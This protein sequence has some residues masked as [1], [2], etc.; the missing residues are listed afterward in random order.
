MGSSDFFE[1]VYSFQSK[2]VYFFTYLPEFN[3]FY[4]MDDTKRIRVLAQD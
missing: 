3:R 1:E 2:W 4:I